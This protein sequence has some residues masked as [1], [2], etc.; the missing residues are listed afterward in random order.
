M[1]QNYA[2]QVDIYNKSETKADEKL[3]IAKSYAE[4]KEQQDVIDISVQQKQNAIESDV[5]EAAK[6]Q[7]EIDALSERSSAV[8]A[9]A[10]DARASV[11][12]V[13]GTTDGNGPSDPY[14]I[15]QATHT[16]GYRSGGYG[17]GES[18]AMSG[19]GGMPPGG[20]GPHN[21]GMP[22]GGMPPNA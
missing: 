5:Q 12:A 22:P 15:T 18:P 11:Q 21:G 2:N 14:G 8:E 4:M 1:R 16:Q 13:H 6:K 10:R 3:S 7:A 19:F 20:D 9:E 17:S